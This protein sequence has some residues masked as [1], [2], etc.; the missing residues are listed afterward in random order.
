M[1][2]TQRARRGLQLWSLGAALAG[3]SACEDARQEPQQSSD[4]VLSLSQSLQSAVAGCAENARSCEAE[5][6]ASCR[7]DFAVCRDAATES[8][9]PAIEAAVSACAEQAK[10]CRDAATSDDAKAACRDQLRTCV[11]EQKPDGGA[12]PAQPDKPD[13]GGKSPV[14]ACISALHTCIEGDQKA[15]VCTEALQQCIA[16]TVGHNGTPPDHD[17]GKPGNDRD[18]E[19]SKPD[20]GQGDRPDAAQGGGKP[21]DKPD[22]AQGGGQPNDRP[23]AAQGGGKP[24]AAGNGADPDAGAADSSKEC[25]SARAAC[26]A[27]GEDK[28]ACARMQRACRDH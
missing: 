2:R 7:D 24:D 23:D 22:A 8:A 16:D 5:A 15:R 26:L 10:T 13:A 11:G 27:N 12:D 21:D 17:A 9:K 18:A 3:M 4:N 25:K 20:A 14:A 1:S 28:D 6:G 19:P